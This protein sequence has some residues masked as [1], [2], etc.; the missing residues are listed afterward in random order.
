MKQE[1][2]INSYY[3]GSDIIT[4]CENF[5]ELVAET[6]KDEYAKRKQYN[7]S[8][9]KQDITLGKIAEWGVYFIYLSRGYKRISVPDMSIYDKSSKSFD[10]DLR[11]GIY[12]LHIKS[13]NLESAER[14]GDSWIFQSKDPLF[15]KSSECDIII[16]CRVGIDDFEKGALIEIKLEKKFSDLVFGETKVSK[17]NGNKK[18]IYLRDNNE[19]G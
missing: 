18:A 2:L 10:S 1:H 11:C 16:G 3:V 5:S 7:L 4:L 8:K 15:V 9:I 14:Y 17:F 6:N 13:Q 19:Q 12:N